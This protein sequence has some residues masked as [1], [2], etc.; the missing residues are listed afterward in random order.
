[1]RSIKSVVFICVLIGVMVAAA[2]T[3]SSCYWLNKKAYLHSLDTHIQTTARLVSNLDKSNLARIM[4]IEFIHMKI[5]VSTENGALLFKTKQFPE[6]KTPKLNTFYNVNDNKKTWRLFYY[7]NT[8]T[9]QRILIAVPLNQHLLRDYLGYTISYIIIAIFVILGLLIYFTFYQSL[10]YIPKLTQELKKKTSNKLEP[11]TLENYPS[12]FQVMIIEL[13]QLFF[14]VQDA[15]QRNKRFSADAAHELRT[16]LTALKTQAQLALQMTDPEEQKKALE[17]VLISVNRSIHVVQQLLTLSRLDHEQEL[18]DVV[19]VNIETICAEMIAYLYPQAL[20]K[21]IEVE[22][23]SE[24]DS[25][26]ILGNDASLG[27]L[28]RNLLDN[29]IRYTPRQGTVEVQLR[30]QA[31]HI[32]LI[33]RDNGPGIPEE[34]R[35]KVFDR[36]FRMLGTKQTGSGLGLAIV[37][38][39]TDL[40]GAEVFLT[41]PKIG[42]GLEVNI[43][44]KKHQ[45]QI[46]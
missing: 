29:A 23:D 16:P 42:T 4:N 9:H 7:D 17:N 5:R 46:D 27:I 12:E 6:F 13:N 40:H 21:T 22:L 38:Q 3:I 34:Y 1:M 11:V 20:E 32:N 30:E 19:P 39:I 26:I 24:C 10:K 43:K 33:V 35:D 41:V 45:A 44:L 8:S 36:F 18:N 37:K 2:V 15:F 25:P 14:R 28:L 31:T